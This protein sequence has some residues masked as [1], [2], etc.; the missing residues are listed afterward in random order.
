MNRVLRDLTE[1]SIPYD[2]IVIDS[3]PS[4]GLLTINTLVAADWILVPVQV[5]YLALE[6][7]T[8]MTQTIQRVRNRY[9]PTWKSWDPGHDVRCAPIGA[10]GAGR[11]ATAPFRA[12][13]S[14]RPSAARCASAKPP[15]SASPSFITMRARQGRIIIINSARRSSMVAKKRGLG[16]GLDAL[17]GEETPSRPNRPAAAGRDGDSFRVANRR[18]RAQSLS[19]APA[20]RSRGDS[21]SWRLRS[22]KAASCS[23]S[24]C[25]A[26]ARA[27]TRSW[28][29]SGVGAPRSAAG[30]PRCR[31]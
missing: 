18:T 15:A 6:G 7:L 16:R 14:K 28:P 22:A 17:L 10:P 26:P 19:A 3:P 8:H 30:W 1:G 2:F 5:E 25:G 20:P 4:L 9:N 12:K 31:P 29:A 23:R 24:S 21:T 27:A 13:S 11:A